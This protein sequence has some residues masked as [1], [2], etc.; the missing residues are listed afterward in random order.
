MGKPSKELEMYAMELCRR[1]GRKCITMYIYS[2]TATKRNISRFM[3][4]LMK[5]EGWKYEQ[6][7]QQEDDY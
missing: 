3:H 2:P 1:Y 4:Q 6:I 7:S 5:E